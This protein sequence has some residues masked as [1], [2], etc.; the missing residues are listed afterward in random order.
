MVAMEPII[1]IS[2][3]DTVSVPALAK[4]YA[5]SRESLVDL[6]ERDRPLTQLKWVDGGVLIRPEDDTDWDEAEFI[7]SIE[8]EGVDFYTFQASIF[9]FNDDTGH[10]LELGYRAAFVPGGGI[11]VENPNTPVAMAADRIW[12]DL[13][14]IF[15][16]YAPERL[17]SWAEYASQIPNLDRLFALAGVE[18]HEKQKQA[19]VASRVGG[20]LADRAQH[21]DT[22]GTSRADELAVGDVLEAVDVRWW[23]H[24]TSRVTYMVSS[25]EPAEDGKLTITFVSGNDRD[26]V[27]TVPADRRFLKAAQD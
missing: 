26:Q 4:L 3:D 21:A 16:I 22:T 18:R 13:T 5:V 19:L 15:G 8:V 10:M 11:V 14:S 24:T 6:F 7:A 9:E 27:L 12:E 17:N 2:F 25:I 20:W 1:W 23:S